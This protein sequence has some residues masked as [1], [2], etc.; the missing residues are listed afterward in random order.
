MLG[1]DAIGL[2]FDRASRR[3]L[4]VEAGARLRRQV[5]A[6]VSVVALFRNSEAALVEAVIES[7][8]PDLLQFHGE[9]GGADCRRYGRRYAK[10]F[11]MGG[12][13]DTSAML[14]EFADASA[15]LLDS[16]APG[17]LG[18]TGRSF[19]WTRIPATLAS[20]VIL[21]GGLS[22]ANVEQAVTMVR[23]F[24]VDVSSGIEKAPGEKDP[25]RMRAFVAA[26][27]RADSGGSGRDSV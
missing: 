23:P 7:V 12:D 2:V 6:F 19:D 21:A 13:A 24:A 27:R 16:H 3:A 1:A 8:Q 22:P 14:A 25:A 20:R 10:A 9:E 11:A 4:D 26:V 17:A 5:P 15:L 18:G